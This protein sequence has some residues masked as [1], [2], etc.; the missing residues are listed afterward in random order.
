MQRLGSKKTTSTRCGKPIFD[1]LVEVLSVG[2]YIVHENVA[3]SVDALLAESGSGVEA[4]TISR[5]WTTVD[6]QYWI[7]YERYGGAEERR[8]QLD[9]AQLG[10]KRVGD[11]WL[12][13]LFG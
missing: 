13:T 8:R 6:G 4:A 11:N 5:R 10:A 7:R 9:A 3:S 2:N 1:V 12:S